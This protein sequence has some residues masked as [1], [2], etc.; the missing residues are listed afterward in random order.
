MIKKYIIDGNNLIGK[1]D[2]LW[3]LQKKEKQLSRLKLVY[4]LEAYFRN[5]NVQVSLHFDGFANESIPT[6]KIKI[7]YSDNIPADQKI[8]KEIDNSKNPKLITVVS[9]DRSVMEYG[10]VNSCTVITSEDFSKNIEQTKRKFTKEEISKSIS[11]EEIKKMFG[12]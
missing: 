12:V 2:E 8:K 10:K 11:D 1:M 7:T 4:K 5:K 3:K 9:S 6:N